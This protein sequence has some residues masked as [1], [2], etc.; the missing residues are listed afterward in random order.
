MTSLEV[1]NSVSNVTDQN[2]SFSITILGYWTSRGG[3]ETINL[4]RGLLELREQVDN[5]RHVEDVTQRGN[6]IKLGGE[7]N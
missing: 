4:L 3:L 1:T 7:E 2:N 6:Q 5:K